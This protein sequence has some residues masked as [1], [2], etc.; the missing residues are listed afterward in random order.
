MYFIHYSGIYSTSG[1]MPQLLSRKVNRYIKGASKSG[2]ENSAS[3]YKDL[4]VFF[5]IGDV[6]L[7]N[8][9]GS[10]WKTLSD[11]CLEYNIADQNW[12]VHT[13]VPAQQFTN[14]VDVDGVEHLYY[15]SY[16]DGKVKEFLAANVTTDEG[17]EIFFRADTQ[18]I[19]VLPNPETYANI[20]GLVTEVERGTLTKTFVSLDKGDYYELKGGACKGISKIKVHARDPEKQEMVLARQFSLSFRDSSKQLCRLLQ[21]AIVYLPTNITPAS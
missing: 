7:Y 3:G 15:T 10:F 9:D 8:G 20:I 17:G 2:L 14:V 18:L 11:V 13:N 5:T 4:C 21:A 12:Y 16:K 1:N 19:Q 6:K